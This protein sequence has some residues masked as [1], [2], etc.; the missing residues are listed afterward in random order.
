MRPEHGLGCSCAEGELFGYQRCLRS[1]ATVYAVGG[2]RAASGVNPRVVSD[3][4]G[5]ASTGFTLDTYAR[6]LSG[7]RAEAAA[8]IARLVF[9]SDS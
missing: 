1:S 2:P 4:L 8:T 6:T 7:W 9:I 5:H 3:R